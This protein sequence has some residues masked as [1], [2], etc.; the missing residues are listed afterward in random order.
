MANKAEADMTPGELAER[1]AE[2]MREVGDG[3]TM[4]AGADMQMRFA[5]V[6]QFTDYFPGSNKVSEEGDWILIK[7]PPSCEYTVPPLSI[8]FATPWPIQNE[9]HCSH[10]VKILTPRG[11][12]GVFP[13]EYSKI[14]DPGKYF[15]FIGDGMEIKFFGNEEGVPKDQLFYIRSRGVSKKDALA[16]LIG[17]IKAHGVMWIEATKDVAA[18][19]GMEFPADHRNATLAI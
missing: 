10:R 3:L 18:S 15:E 13:R 17:N 5:A 19:F 11:E 1:E 4:F 9:R 2:R 14:N 6:E 8:W 12:L 7:N 16:L